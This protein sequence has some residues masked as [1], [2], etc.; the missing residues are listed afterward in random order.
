MFA[1]N[2]NALGAVSS[3]HF[4]PA[5]TLGLATARRFPVAEVVPYWIAQ[6]AGA[7]V[8]AVVRKLGL[9][10]Q[11]LPLALAGGVLLGSAFYR[12]A[13]LRALAPHVRGSRTAMIAGAGH[14][15]FEQAPKEFCDA[16]LEFLGD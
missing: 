4:N 6:L 8:A 2:W 13:V 7:L 15:M 16:V 5:V 11:K 9:A 10:P 1:W 3:G 12:Q 14:W